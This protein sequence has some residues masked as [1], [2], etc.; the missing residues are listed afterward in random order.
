MVPIDLV[1][2]AMDSIRRR[3]VLFKPV[4]ILASDPKSEFLC[5]SRLV[6]QNLQ[7]L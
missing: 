5:Q 6:A 4:P 1:S 7:T 2:S 3:V